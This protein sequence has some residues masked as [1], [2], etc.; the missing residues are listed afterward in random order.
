MD[1]PPKGAAAPTLP[2][3]DTRAGE[4]TNTSPGRNRSRNRNPGPTQDLDHSRT[5]AAYNISA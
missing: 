3:P 4:A 5:V 2:S 1:Q